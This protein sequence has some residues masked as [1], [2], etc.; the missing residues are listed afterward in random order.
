MAKQ[1]EVNPEARLESRPS[2]VRMSLEQYLQISLFDQ[3]K[4]KIKENKWP[5]AMVVRRY[6]KGEVVC[7]QGEPGWT[8]FYILT[9]ED[10]YKL[11]L[12]QLQTASSTAERN[13]IQSEITTVGQRLSLL[14][15]G[16]DPE[17]LRTAASVHL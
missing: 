2:D 1:I 4:N 12:S 17:K 3:L 11:E 8:A 7:R 9:S 14:R 13:E 10:M 15:T 16:G 5:G 6:R